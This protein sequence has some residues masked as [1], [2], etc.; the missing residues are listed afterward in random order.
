[1]LYQRLGICVVIVWVGRE[2]E[3][4]GCSMVVSI[5]TSLLLPAFL[6]SQGGAPSPSA[7]ELIVCLGL[8]ACSG[9]RLPPVHSRS[10]FRLVF[11]NDTYHPF[12][13]LLESAPPFTSFFLLLVISDHIG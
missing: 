10:F 1:M 12:P 5:G 3:K 9:W 6:L 2:K 8:H 4:E 11:S 7:R 13:I